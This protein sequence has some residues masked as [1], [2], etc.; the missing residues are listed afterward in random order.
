VA[1]CCDVY[2]WP[3]EQRFKGGTGKP[4]LLHVKCAVADGRW[5][6]LSSANLTEYAFSV[7]MELGVLI[8]GG[9]APVQV[10]AHFAKMIALG[11]FV[12]A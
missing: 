10:E 4:G 8:T 5:L 7:N 3:I 6:F 12:R 9:T 2:L 1:G 11:T